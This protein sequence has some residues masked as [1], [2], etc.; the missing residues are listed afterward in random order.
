MARGVLAELQRLG[1]WRA[2]AKFGVAVSGGADSVALLFL[3]LELQ[4][5]LRAEAPVEIAV[6]HFNHQ[7]RG[8]AADADERF[9]RKL[10]EAHDLEFYVD[11]TNVSAQAKRAKQNVEDTGRRARYAFFARLAEEGRV[12]W[13][14]T[15]HTMDDQAETVLAHLLRGTGLAGLGGIHPQSG[16]IVRPLLGV[17]R[18]ELR[19]YLKLRAQ[20]WRE[21]ASNRD[22]SKTRARIRKKLLPLLEKEFQPE[23]AAHLT[24]LAQRAR[25]DEE[26]LESAATKRLADTLRD[27]GDALRVRMEDLVGRATPPALRGRMVRRL[28]KACKGH[29]GELGAV[30]VASILELAST[31]ENGKMLRLPGGVEVRREREA[32]S[33][34]AHAGT[35]AGGTAIAY[36]HEVALSAP[37]VTVRV[38]SLLCAFRFT[39]IDWVGDRRETSNTR[40]V[41]DRARLEHPLVLRNWRPGDRLQPAGRNSVHKLKRLLNEQGV[42]RWARNGWPVLA[43]GLEIIWARGF[44]VAAQYAAHAGTKTALLIEEEPI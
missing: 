42:S 1:V 38:P 41:A 33:F 6:A 26:F 12:E 31:G 40:A 5:D 27:A 21:D 36:A 43:S 8:A 17:R 15:A 22:T 30:H 37:S 25:E 11:S 28:V 32:L 35:G 13:V 14:A 23:T 16:A 19:S 20:T 18:A 3:F 34:R 24:A 10:A 39:K 7:L 29:D 2:G 9:V 4:A 44:G